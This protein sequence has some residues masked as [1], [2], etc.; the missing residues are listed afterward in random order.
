MD[1]VR[2]TLLSDVEI[3]K[4]K[5]KSGV[6]AFSISTTLAL[7]ARD[8]DVIRKQLQEALATEKTTLVREF[9]DLLHQQARSEL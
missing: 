5:A 7:K 3:K 9:H 2:S 6:G 1:E 8:N 4:M